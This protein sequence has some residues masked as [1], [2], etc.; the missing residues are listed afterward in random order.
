MHN[1][2]CFLQRSAIKVN[3]SNVNTFP[4]GLLGVLSMMT[5]VLALN[6]PSNSALSS[7]KSAEDKVSPSVA[8]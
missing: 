3:S 2:L 5:L 8:F 1:T 4:R 7:V 6:N